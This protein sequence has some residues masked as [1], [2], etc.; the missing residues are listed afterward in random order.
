MIK[1]E[2]PGQGDDTRGWGP[3]FLE[4]HPVDC[5][6]A[7]TKA[8]PLSCSGERGQTVGVLPL[9]EQ[10]QAIDNVRYLPTAR[11]R[12]NAPCGPTMRA[13][14]LTDSPHPAGCK[15]IRKLATGCDVLV[16]NFKV[17]GL[18]KYRLDYPS[19]KEINPGTS[20]ADPIHSCSDTIGDP[21]AAGIVYCS[22]TGFGQTGPRKDQAGYDFL[23]QAQTPQRTI[24]HSSSKSL[25]HIRACQD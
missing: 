7:V 22:I 19:V 1:V 5:P 9:R 20:P 24:L 3:P 2:R 12:G 15:I 18:A 16:E 14:A 8:D 4:A 25:S 11:S 23:L 10:R 6:Q 13:F 21:L 17:G